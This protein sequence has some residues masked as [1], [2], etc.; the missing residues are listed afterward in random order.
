MLGTAAQITNL[1]AYP[2][3]NPYI[4]VDV[5]PTLPRSG[6]EHLLFSTPGNVY[7]LPAGFTVVD[8][9]PPVI[10]ALAPAGNGSGN[11]AI[12]GAAVHAEHANLV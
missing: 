1:R 6:P 8:A 11:V 9:P 12:A 7:V 5:M 2:P 3:G 10:S 4:A